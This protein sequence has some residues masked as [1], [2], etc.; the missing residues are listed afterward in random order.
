M[1]YEVA[2]YS[3]N[4]EDAVRC[5]PPDPLLC[6]NGR[7][8]DTAKGWEAHRRPELLSLLERECYGV[9]LPPPDELNIRE[10]SRKDDA[11][12]GLATRKEWE[13][14]C[15]MRNGRSFSFV[16]LVYLPNHAKGPVPAFL[17]LNFKGNHNTTTEDDV[18]KTGYVREGELAVPERGVQAY[19]WCFEEVVRR[20][21][22]SATICYHDIHPDRTHETGR[23][24]FSLFFDEAE[25]PFIRR[26]HSVIGAWAWGL[27]RGLDALEREPAIDASRVAVHGHSRLGKTSLWAGAV[28]Q[29]FAMVISNDS[30]CGGAALHKR[31]FGENLSQ[32]FEAH[33]KQGVPFWFLEGMRRYIWH[34]ETLP[35][36]QH[37]LLAMAAPRPLCVASASDDFYADPEGEFLACHYAS[38]VYELYGFPPFADEKG[39]PRMIAPGEHCPGRLH[40]HYRKGVHD[41]TE[42]DWKHYLE[43]ADRFLGPNLSH[44]V[45]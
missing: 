29:R 38:P 31:K 23:S 27:S 34:E 28:D 43:Q 8:V 11:L 26:T 36:D 10:F 15:R 19:R 32:H 37:E 13:I 40:Y 9:P 16:M 39:M 45:R 5:I 12:G 3:I 18:L 2:S 44:D 4:P 24:C 33:E 17:G 41:Q 20:G 1:E 14:C 7:R 42:F 21:Y 30:G 6:E 22:A 25:Y 35:F